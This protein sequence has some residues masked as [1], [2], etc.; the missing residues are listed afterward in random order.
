[1]PEMRGPLQIIAYT[2]GLAILRILSHLGLGR[3]DEPPPQIREVIRVP[4][5]DEGR[6]VARTERAAHL[7]ASAEK[8]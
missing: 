1:M 8:A 7:T 2:N 5:D 4:V 3:E 6:E